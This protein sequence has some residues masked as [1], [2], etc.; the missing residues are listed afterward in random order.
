MEVETTY[1]ELGE[2]SS[3]VSIELY[4]VK[5]AWENDHFIV[6]FEQSQFS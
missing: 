3:C 2:C 1:L 5:S 4:A 6:D